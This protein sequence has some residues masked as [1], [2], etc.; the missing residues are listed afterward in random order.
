LPLVKGRYFN[1]IAQPILSFAY[2]N[3]LPLWDDEPSIAGSEP[4]IALSS[5]ASTKGSLDIV[6]AFAPG[7]RLFQA[8]LFLGD[9][10]AMLG[11]SLRIAS[12][13]FSSCGPFAYTRMFRNIVCIPL[14]P[15]S[16]VLVGTGKASAMGC[17]YYPGDHKVVVGWQRC[18]NRKAT[19]YQTGGA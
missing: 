14:M 12:L 8:A 7:F 17:K 4:E 19:Q 3:P 5:E 16:L 18:R 9:G 11:G 15:V 6:V 2:S 10:D 1:V 13:I